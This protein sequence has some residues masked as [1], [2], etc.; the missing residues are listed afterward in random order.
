MIAIA[1]SPAHRACRLYDKIQ[2]AFLPVRD[3]ASGR[4]GFQIVDCKLS[5][6]FGHTRYPK[7]PW[8][9]ENC[10]LAVTQCVYDNMGQR[11]KRQGETV[12]Y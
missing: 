1:D 11:R 2:A 5:E 12:V 10:S 4:S 8:V 7:V 6:C 9:S 3:L